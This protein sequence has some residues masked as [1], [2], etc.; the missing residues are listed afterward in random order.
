VLI[1]WG[2]VGMAVYKRYEVNRQT[3]FIMPE[4]DIWEAFK[5]LQVMLDRVVTSETA[6]AGLQTADL[7]T[8]TIL[9]FTD[10]GTAS[11]TAVGVAFTLAKLL[12]ELYLLGREFAETRDAR[13][14]LSKPDN[15]DTKLFA[16]Y[17]L[18][19]CHMLLAS[20]TSELINM[21]WAGTMR[22]GAIRFGDLAWREQVLWVKR[23]SVDPVLYRA[24]EMVYNSPF[25]VRDAR[26]KRG[27]PVHELYR[28]GLGT[29][30]GQKASK[31]GASLDVL[32]VVR[33]A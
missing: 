13:E 27:M 23:H 15:L 16:A 30:L 18:L 3:R 22:K 8:R 20:E 5:A 29:R 24:A 12:H 31:V 6:Q 1:A 25:L 10:L 7:A 19:G 2:K 21:V 33:A 28:A 17:P 32:Q 26:T 11:S 4:G 14:L 9:S